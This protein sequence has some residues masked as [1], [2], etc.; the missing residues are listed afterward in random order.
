MPN[1]EF[2][3]IATLVLT[4]ILVAALVIYLTGI[5]I[6]LRRAGTHLEGVAEALSEIESNTAP[7]QDK[8][9]TI[10]SALD[11]LGDGLASVDG[12]LVNIAKV[13]RL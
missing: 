2:L 4:G 8:V 10:N 12:R 9:G 6:A 1:A 7:L 5:L 13:F 3:T 11:Q